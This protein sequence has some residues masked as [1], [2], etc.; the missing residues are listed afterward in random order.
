MACMNNQLSFAPID[1]PDTVIVT[2]SGSESR[3]D[4]SGRVGIFQANVG[5]SVLGD[6]V[7]WST[8]MIDF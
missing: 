3:K 1:S 8:F 6:R 7:K 5:K 2:S 4:A